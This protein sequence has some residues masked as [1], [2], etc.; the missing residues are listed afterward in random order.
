MI[1][2][3]K[4]KFQVVEKNK[5]LGKK[6]QAENK[7]CTLGKRNKREPLGRPRM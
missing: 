4:H 6:N 7:R 5:W 3:N 2:K 1:T